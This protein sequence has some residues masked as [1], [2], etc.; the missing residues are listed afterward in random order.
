[1]LFLFRIS[2]VDDDTLVPL[3][4]DEAELEEDLRPTE[5]LPTIGG[6]VDERPTSVRELDKFRQS[7]HWRGLGGDEDSDA[8]E[9]AAVTAALPIPRF[10]HNIETTTC[11]RLI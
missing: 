3:H 11:F 1:M 10:A 2:I 6:Y 4:D 7:H 5:E 9:A 8:D